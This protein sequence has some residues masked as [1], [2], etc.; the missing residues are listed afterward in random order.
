MDLLYNSWSSFLEM[1]YSSN[2]T[3]TEQNGQYFMI[4][5]TEFSDDY[6]NYL[7]HEA[8]TNPLYN[9]I[10]KN[11][12]DMIKIDKEYNII[13]NSNTQYTENEY[14][15]ILGF[16]LFYKN[17]LGLDLD[18]FRDYFLKYNRQ[19]LDNQFWTGSNQIF[20]F[21]HIK[22]V[23]DLIN[24][25]GLNVQEGYDNFMNGVTQIINDT[26]YLSNTIYSNKDFLDILIKSII[27][28][29]IIN[30]AVVNLDI[31]FTNFEYLDKDFYDKNYKI[32]SIKN[33]AVL[34]NYIVENRDIIK[35]NMLNRQ[36]QDVIS[37]I[38]FSHNILKE[39]HNI[40][41]D[42]DDNIINFYSDKYNGWSNI[43]AI[44]YQQN[45]YGT[46]KF[47]N[48]YVFGKYSLDKYLAILQTYKFYIPYLRNNYHNVSDGTVISEEI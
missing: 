22:F 45:I 36:S 15:N 14:N 5:I 32:K 18:I 16:L 40:I 34:L 47:I 25:K 10:G 24:L 9:N 30:G 13:I 37:E 33:N 31:F 11:T 29:F 41:S 26:Y 19:N 27:R 39:L 43:V 17:K 35:N 4:E 12:D 44:D 2:R 48:T 46:G 3:N 21:N 20:L 42:Y 38:L 8:F 7:R 6:L 23:D 28:I 1:F